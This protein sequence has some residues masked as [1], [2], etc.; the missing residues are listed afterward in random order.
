VSRTLV[1]LNTRP[2]EQAAEL[3]ELL[4]AAGYAPIEAP[5][6]RASAAWDPPEMA[7][8]LGRLR[9]DA[10]TWLVLPSSNALRFL[11]YGLASVGGAPAD[12]GRV[13]ILCGM[14]TAKAVAARGLNPARILDRFSAE[15]ALAVLDS[16]PLLV[17]RALE[18]TWPSTDIEVDAPVCYRT[19][20]VE[21]SDLRAAAR[22]LAAGEIQVVTFASPSAVHGL[23]AAS[24]SIGRARVV[25]LGSTTAHAARAAGLRVD[26]IAER[27]SMASLVEAVSTALSR[28]KVPA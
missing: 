8:V 16:E 7:R 23:L 13:A 2:R 9:A 3:S 24:T 25:C 17:P 6:T 19:V 27:T 22:Q 11:L 14:G 28:R 26:A 10:Y 21:P 20:P 5:A 15:A 1:V 12:L 4:R 18:S